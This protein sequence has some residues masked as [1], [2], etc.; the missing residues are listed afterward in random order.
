MT[1]SGLG[2]PERDY[3]FSKDQRF[4]EIRG[5]YEKHIDNVFK[6]AGRK[7]SAAVAKRLMEPV[8][9]IRTL[10]DTVPPAVAAAL[11]RALAKSP[12]DR[13]A[14]VEAFARLMDVDDRARE[15]R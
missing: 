2:L 13:F 3:Y 10:R 7:D 11:G 8:P 6:L 12:A 9:Q 4:T 1:Q 14:D 5:A 15:R